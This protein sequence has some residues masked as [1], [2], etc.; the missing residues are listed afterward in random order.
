MFEILGSVWWLL[1]ALG[2]DVLYFFV[3]LLTFEFVMEE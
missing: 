1:V 3:A 2:F